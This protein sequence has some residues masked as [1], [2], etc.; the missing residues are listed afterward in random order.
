MM[1]F[2]YQERVS[3]IGKKAE[4]L[5]TKT[6]TVIGLGG[7][8][9]VVAEMLTREGINLRIIDKGRVELADL[10]RQTLFLEEDDNKF[11]AKQAKKR[12]EDINPKTTIKTFH[13]ELVDSNVFLVDSD[14]IIDCSND[15]DTMKLVANYVKKKMPLVNCKYGGC[16]G[17]IFISDKKYL[18]SK[19]VDKIKI[20]EIKKEGILNA[21]THLAAGIIVSQAIKTLVG[22]KITDNFIVYDVWK[23][24]IRRVSI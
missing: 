4:E 3:E 18:F 8:G 9:T 14:L 6:V 15:L 19:V 22:E 11:K 24:N 5:R 23:D 16:Q 13:E 7:L 17:A 2:K 20:P 12:L 1:K 10:Q 21:T